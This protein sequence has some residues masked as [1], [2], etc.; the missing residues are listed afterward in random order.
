MM[1]A[2]TALAAWLADSQESQG[3]AVVAVSGGFATPFLLPTGTDAQAALFTYDAILITGT[4]VLAARRN[5]PSLNIVSYVFTALTFLSWVAVF[6]APSK[7]LTTQ[8]FLTLFCAMFLY[9]LY[10]TYRSADLLAVLARVVLWTAPIGY[11]ALSVANLFEHDVA[12]L[13][14]LVVVALIGVITGSRTNAW[15][16]LLFW[17]AV[18]APLLAWSTAHRGQPSALYSA[19]APWIGIYLLNLAGLFAVLPNA[20]ATFGEA[21]IALLHL[22][23]LVTYFGLYLLLGSRYAAVDAAV[24][25]GFGIFNLICAFLVR[26][27]S[28]TQALH[29][30]ALA[31]TFAVI[32][33]ALELSGPWITIGWATEA[34]LV[35]WLALHERRAWL[36][37]AGLALFAAAV[38]RLVASQMAPPVPGQLLVL[39]AR[40]LT[41]VFVVALTYALAYLHKRYR[42]D[43]AHVTVDITAFVILA[44]VLTL[45]VLTT[46]IN[47]YWHVYDT[48][49][50]STFASMSMRFA[51]EVTLSLTWA[52]YAT[53]LVIVGLMRRY[54]PI[55][56]FAMTVFAVTILKVFAVDL[57]ELDRIYRVL[58]IIGLGITL[59]VTSY[60]Y[61]KL[62]AES[63][64]TS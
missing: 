58:S 57:A 32:V 4:L 52:V 64:A 47:A 6:Y 16:R 24:A 11:H 12:L 42:E 56:Y 46:E 7:Y 25:A 62:S 28:R 8:L 51:R 44:S 35:T 40:G 27:R 34:V 31:G 17:F 53:I 23:G 45:G 38:G 61:Q 39:N 22:N 63:E 9:A 19:Q 1:L 29:F 15:I 18:A 37:V 3:L 26:N 5:W 49:R 60:L 36:R 20:I 41:G 2:I 54:A 21:D 55:R 43:T 10:T 13:I 30:I 50:T 14:Y 33:M 59:L 48:R